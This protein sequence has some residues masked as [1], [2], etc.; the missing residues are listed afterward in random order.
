MQRFGSEEER[1]QAFP[2]AGKRIFLAHAGVTS[3]PA[4]AAGAM[5]AYITES[6][7]D[8]QEFGGVLKEITSTRRDAA[9]LACTDL[10]RGRQSRQRYLV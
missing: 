4:C 9:A 8:Q 3:L 6:S 1:L 7:V 10:D 2:V 5:T